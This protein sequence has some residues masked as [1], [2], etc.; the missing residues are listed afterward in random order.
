[1]SSWICLGP[2]SGWNLYLIADRLP[3]P[4]QSMAQ[5]WHKDQDC[6]TAGVCFLH[7]PHYQKSFSFFLSK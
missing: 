3:G 4:G 6:V 1:M 2:G 5:S 7:F